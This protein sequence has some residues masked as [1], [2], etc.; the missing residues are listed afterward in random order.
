MLLVQKDACESELYNLMHSYLHYTC[1]LQRQKGGIVPKG[2]RR[3]VKLTHKK[4]LKQ[5]DWPEWEASETKQ[6]D[7]YEK[8][9]MFSSPCPLLPHANMLPFLWMYLI[10]DDGTKKAKCVCN[11]APSKG[12]VTLGPTYAGSLDQTGARVF[13]SV[14]AMRNLKVYGTDVSN[15]FTEAPPPVAP[16]Y[17]TVD[18]QYRQWY[19]R[20]GKGD[21]PEGYVLK[22]KRALQGHPEAACLWSVLIDKLIKEKLG[23]QATTHKP[24]LYSGKYKGSEVLFLRQVD[25][26]TIACSDESIAKDMI[27]K[28]NSFMSV[29]IKYLGLLTRYNGV[30]VDQCKEYIKIYNTT[31]IDKILHGHRTW[32]EDKPCHTLPILIVNVN[33]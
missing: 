22:V 13:W 8:Q 24:C 5:D 16:L 19:K 2:R 25:N 4:L 26:F 12:T 20:N 6:L 29:Q 32:I 11:G 14:A 17:I 9:Q 3:G 30:D 15:A 28:I 1:R 10:K 7:Q 21:I 27:A 23:L 33:E 18:H 31:Y